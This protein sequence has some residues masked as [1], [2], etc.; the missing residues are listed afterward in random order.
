MYLQAEEYTSL[1]QDFRIAHGDQTEPKKLLEKAEKL[2]KMARSRATD[3]KSSWYN[4][5]EHGLDALL[6][7]NDLKFM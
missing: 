1:S 4:V 2:V 6:S 7:R 3:P 5:I